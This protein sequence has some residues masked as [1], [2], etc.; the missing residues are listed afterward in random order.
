MNSKQSSTNR[1]HSSDDDA[2]YDAWWEAVDE[3]L[4]EFFEQALCGGEEREE[5]VAKWKTQLS[6]SELWDRFV[7]DC[8]EFTE[9]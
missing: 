2:G 3:T 8:L 4:H 6:S 1:S 7:D 9:A 5:V